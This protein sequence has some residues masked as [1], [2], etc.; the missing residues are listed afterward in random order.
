MSVSVIKVSTADQYQ[1][2]L[3]VRKK[4][5]REEQQWAA[6]DEIDEH[7]ETSIHFLALINGQPAGTARFRIHKGMIKFERVATLPGFRGRGVGSQVILKM[8]EEIDSHYPDYLPIMHAQ[9]HASGFYEKLGWI[10]VSEPFIELGNEVI[11]MIR[12]PKQ[13]KQLSKLKCLNDKELP[14]SIQEYIHQQVF[15]NQQITKSFHE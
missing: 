1:D 14:E 2:C 13:T 12:P 5:F 9:M 8:L 15:Q 6:D 10:I 3:E 7:E 4:V 11:V